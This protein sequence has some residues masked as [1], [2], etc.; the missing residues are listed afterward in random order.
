[1]AHK[2]EDI[3]I[4]TVG[5]FHVGQKSFL[6]SHISRKPPDPAIQSSSLSMSHE[7]WRSIEIEDETVPDGSCSLSVTPLPYHITFTSEDPAY[8]RLRWVKYS[9][10]SIIFLCY[11]VTRQDSLMSIRRKWIPEIL[12]HHPGTPNCPAQHPLR[13]ILLGLHDDLLSDPGI[14]QS[15]DMKEEI[16]RITARDDVLGAFTCSAYRSESTDTVVRSSIMLLLERERRGNKRTQCA[17]F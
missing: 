7:G 3:E 16:E 15:K 4:V 11:H 12:E 9:I 13:M 2:R 10:S 8:E 1:M 14:E 6:R 5:D 17:V